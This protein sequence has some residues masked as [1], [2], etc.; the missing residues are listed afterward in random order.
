[1]KLR[2]ILTEGVS[3]GDANN[4][5]YNLVL[6]HLQTDKNTMSDIK[7][8][9]FNTD[10]FWTSELD[11]VSKGFS[12]S[13]DEAI[14]A[15]FVAADA[16]GD[17]IKDHYGNAWNHEPG[18]KKP[19]KLDF[20]SD[21]IPYDEALETVKKLAP[22]LYEKHVEDQAAAKKAASEQQKALIKALLPL[23]PALAHTIINTYEKA[24][25]NYYKFLKANPND[26]ETKAFT[27][28]RK[29]DMNAI[30]N[31]K[32]LA[33]AV[34]K[35]AEDEGKPSYW[36]D[37]TYETLLNGDDLDEIDRQT[38]SSVRWHKNTASKLWAL[39]SHKVGK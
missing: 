21:D 22:D 15:I 1:M 27:S 25:N 19:A 4:A 36:M 14:D 29:L 35:A 18:Y 24:W 16:I 23:L 34:K 32:E 37:D 31:G 30:K 9:M 3:Q 8:K 12:R 17:S 28:E 10:E 26:W 5:V 39:V 20:S 11:D 6:A 38:L 7:D 13:V 33:A 2:H